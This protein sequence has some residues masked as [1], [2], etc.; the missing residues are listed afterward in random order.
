MKTKKSFSS[1]F[2]AL[3]VFMPMVANAEE[4]EIDS[5]WYNLVT[6]TKQAEVIQYRTSDKYWGDIVIP[7][8][9]SY[10]DVEYNVTSIGEAA[11]AGCSSLT[12]IPIGSGMRNIGSQ[13]FA[14][15]Q[16]LLDVYCYAEAVPF[17]ESDAFDGSYPEYATLHV[18]EVSLEAYRTTI[19]WSSFG[20]FMTLD[21]DIPVI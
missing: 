5:L 1:L 19:P 3:L 10:Q 21:G 11:L 16:E 6:N 13:A 20:T 12:S 8:V 7:D 9:V 2:I 15:C 4:V 17:T 18:P 14:N